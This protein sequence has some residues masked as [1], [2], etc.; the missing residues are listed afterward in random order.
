MRE[1]T[2]F[3][4]G[5]IIVCCMWMEK[6]YYFFQEEHLKWYACWNPFKKMIWY[7]GWFQCPHIERGGA[8]FGCI[9]HKCV[10]CRATKELGFG[11][12]GG[13]R[14]LWRGATKKPK[15][16]D[17]VPN[18]HGT[19]LGALGMRQCLGGVVGASGTLWECCGSMGTRQRPRSGHGSCGNKDYR[20]WNKGWISMDGQEGYIKEAHRAP[21][22]PHLTSHI[23][24]E[25][26]KDSSGTYSCKDFW[27]LLKTTLEELS[28]IPLEAT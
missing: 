20:E 12:W 18:A 3:L 21:K 22:A 17:V 11:M 8:C 7:Q 10:G 28:K 9:D 14:S 25:H 24:R 1:E 13:A 4:H 2:R 6:E 26:R 15:E 19:L 27:R 5:M 16:R 23:S